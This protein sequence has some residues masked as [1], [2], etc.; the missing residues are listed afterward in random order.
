MATRA[1][2]RRQYGAHRRAAETHRRGELANGVELCTES[3]GD[4]AD[5]P[6]LAIMGVGSSMHW[7]DERFCRLL[8]ECGRFMIRYD[9][10]DTGRS[11]TYEPGLP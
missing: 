2:L 10:R 4:P 7:C 8:A 11:I 5:P 3:F 6:I 1:Q 9:H